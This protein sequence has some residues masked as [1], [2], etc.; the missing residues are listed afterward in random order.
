M[1][2]RH[3]PLQVFHGTATQAAIDTIISGGFKVG[4]T[5]GIAIANGAVHGRGVYTATGPATPMQSYA[6]STSQVILCRALPGQEGP[7]D[8]NGVDMWRPRRDWAVFADAASLLPM[9]VV[10]F[11]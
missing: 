7:R 5:E 9:Y 11:G 3:A 10:R 6:G 8:S 1:L 4:G 2:P